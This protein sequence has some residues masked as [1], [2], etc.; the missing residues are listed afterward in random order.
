MET[1]ELFLVMREDAGLLPLMQSRIPT[2][3]SIITP[4]VTPQSS[5]P[6]SE[7]GRHPRPESA[8]PTPARSILRGTGPEVN[9]SRVAELVRRKR[10][11][12]RDMIPY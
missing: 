9:L 7:P 5:A 2:T 3:F 1:S 6:K 12:S 4:E 11:V 10:S 8:P